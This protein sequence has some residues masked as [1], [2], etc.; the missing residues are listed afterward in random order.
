MGFSP[1]AARL[2]AFAEAVL[3][4]SDL[5]VGPR[6]VA[7]LFQETADYIEKLDRRKRKHK[8]RTPP[9]GSQRPNRRL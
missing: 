8:R 3:G 9:I 6:A 2:R 5:K 1:R 4:E 7:S